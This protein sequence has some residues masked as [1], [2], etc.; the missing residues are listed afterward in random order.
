[1]FPDHH[2][3]ILLEPYS[4]LQ[5][6]WLSAELLYQKKLFLISSVINILIHYSPKTITIILQLILIKILALA[7]KSNL[8]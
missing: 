5:D 7:K 4:M 3:L 8:K 2:N 1:M 6:Q